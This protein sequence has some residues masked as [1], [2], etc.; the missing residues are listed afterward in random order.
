MDDHTIEILYNTQGQPYFERCIMASS[1]SF[2]T[3]ITEANHPTFGVAKKAADVADVANNATAL[4]TTL[5][6]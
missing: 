5:R 1:F 3:P 2:Y 6:R 4:N